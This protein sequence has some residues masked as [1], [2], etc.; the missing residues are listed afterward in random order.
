M[1]DERYDPESIS[2]A[3]RWLFRLIA[4]SLPF[5]ALI[6]AIRIAEYWAS[7][8]VR[9]PNQIMHEHFRLNHVNLTRHYQTETRYFLD[10]SGERYLFD[11]EINS[12]GWREDYEVS[13]N[14]PDSVY[15]IFYVGDSFVEGTAPA[16]STVPCLV[17][18]ELNKNYSGGNQR[19]EVINA[20][21]SSYSPSIFYV[22]IRYYLLEYS[23]DLI[24]INVDMTDDYDEWKYSSTLVLDDEGNPYAVPHRTISGAGFIDTGEGARRMTFMSRVYLFFYENSYVFNYL[25]KNFPELHFPMNISSDTE[26][27]EDE[28]IYDRWAWCRYDRDEKTRN[29]VAKTLDYLR[30]TLELCREHRIK[31]A[32]TGVP[33]Y[34]QYALDPRTGK[35]LWSDRP[36]REIARVAEECGAFYIDSFNFLKPYVTGT[37]QTRYYYYDDMHF[38]PTGYWLWSRAHIDALTD[39]END[40]L[41]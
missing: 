22:L 29:N 37:G 40:L 23:P 41:R 10:D 34:E 17:E 28:F 13:I 31:V 16:D 19:F 36:H 15:R 20:G 8:R 5:L 26:N 7:F 21:T 25:R 6:A 4:V 3:R 35:P 27:P 14:K 2:P 11:I 39:P 12:K 24:V 38:N 32:V 1:S 18:K 33:H 30:R 9:L